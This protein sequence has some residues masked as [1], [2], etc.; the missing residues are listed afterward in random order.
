MIKYFHIKKYTLFIMYYISNH[1][2]NTKKILTCTILCN[3]VKI[4][5]ELFIGT[6]GMKFS[7][8]DNNAIK[9]SSFELVST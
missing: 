5:I 7:Y 2:S 9:S 8:I 4:D 6:K 1:L 3:Y